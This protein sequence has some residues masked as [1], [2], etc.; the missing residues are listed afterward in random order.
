MDIKGGTWCHEPWVLYKTSESWPLPLKPIIRNMLIN[1]INKIR[2]TFFK[3]ERK[4]PDMKEYLLCNFLYWSKTDPSWWK[5]DKWLPE[6]RVEIDWDEAQ[7]NLLGRRI[8][9]ISWLW[10][11]YIH[12]DIYQNS[13]N[14]PLK[15]VHP[16]VCKLYLH[17][18]NSNKN[19]SLGT[20][21]N[22]NGYLGRDRRF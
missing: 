8:C 4:K 14:C 11:D 5:T 15:C 19:N 17:R 12:G 18:A 6:A 1:W 20:N 7:W 21:K 2:F 22:A 9:P 10:W 3:K 16:V 13:L